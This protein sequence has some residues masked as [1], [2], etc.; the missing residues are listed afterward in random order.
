MTVHPEQPQRRLLTMTLAVVAAA[1]ALALPFVLTGHVFGPSRGSAQRPQTTSTTR[2]G[3]AAALP[4][5]ANASPTTPG[6]PPGQTAVS[7]ALQA[8]RL[9]N[10]RQQALVNKAALTLAQFDKHIEVMNALAAGKISLSVATTFWDQT[11]VAAAQNAAAFLSADKAQAR[12][13]TSCKDLE[14]N[15]AGVATASQGK[16]ISECATAI[17]LRAMVLQRA[18]TAVT[19]WQHHVH[20]MEML[21]SG[22]ITP[23]QA[24][25]MWRQNWKTGDTQLRAYETALQNAGKTHCSLV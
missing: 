4:A 6:V 16:A 20:G 14:A 23:A 7:A 11:R 5:T 13:T 15:L 18:R 2:A 24:T 8:C 19:T 3:D 21:R 9:A 25:A 22:R 12:Y 10:L 1:L 17:E